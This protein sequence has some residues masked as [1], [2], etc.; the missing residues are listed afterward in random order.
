MRTCA[1]RSLRLRR[2]GCDVKVTIDDVE[3]RPHHL[4]E[5]TTH[6]KSVTQLFREAR[7]HARLTLEQVSKG[8]GIN[9][10][11]VNRAESGTPNLITAMILTEFYGIPPTEIIRSVLHHRK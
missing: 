7:A 3:Y 4:A 9:M 1:H 5:T 10:S 11:Q 8:A 2:W 6:V